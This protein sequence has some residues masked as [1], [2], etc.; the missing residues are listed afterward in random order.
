MDT[1][2]PFLAP[3]SVIFCDKRWKPAVVV[4]TSVI[5]MTFIWAFYLLG[6]SMDEYTLDDYSIKHHPAHLLHGGDGIQV[7]AGELAALQGKVRSAVV[8]IHGKGQLQRAQGVPSIL[9][10]G[11]IVHP[12]GY[13]LTTAHGITNHPNLYADVITSK[14]PQRYEV[15]LVKVDIQSNLALLKVRSAER[16]LFLKMA[17]TGEMEPGVPLYAFG[18]GQNSSMIGK[19]GSLIQRGVMLQAGSQK[20]SRLFMTDSVYSWEQ[21]GGA[22]VTSNAELAGINLAMQGPD[23]QIQGYAVPAHIIK[24]VFADELSL[25]SATTTKVVQ[26]ADWP[27]LG[28][29]MAGTTPIAEATTN[30]IDVDHKNAFT[31]SGHS[32]ESAVGLVLL[33]LA[34]GIT[35]GMITMGGGIILVSGMFIFF[36]YGMHLIRPVAFITNVFTYGAASLRNKSAGLVMWD[37]VKGLVPWA[38]VGV[39]VGYLIGSKLDDQV[40]GYML[41]LFALLMAAKTLHEIF[42]GEEEQEIIYSTDGSRESE[43]DTSETAAYDSVEAMMESMDA[44]TSRD[45]GISRGRSAL[46]ENGILGIPMGLV[47]GILGISGGVVEVPLQRHFAKISLHNAIANSSVMVFWA[48]LAAAVVSLVHGSTIGA[49]EWQTPLGIALIMIPS[50]YIGGMLGAKMLRHI[51]VDKLKWIYVALMLVVGI[52]MLFGQ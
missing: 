24:K 18:L 37:K 4:L 39:I 32:I 43:V 10:S 7:V 6:V 33:G 11:V 8:H 12:A 45:K 13:L 16:F 26:M 52:R 5:L 3:N 29:N 31:I 1:K 38:V 51:Q 42:Q 48:S 17:E 50:S 14:G 22:L 34:A 46:L 36:G 2:R 47:S 25:A 28:M 44:E 20:I 49:F 9:A 21:T 30:G 41:G 27:T 23:G 40:V 35:G 19:Q 15:R